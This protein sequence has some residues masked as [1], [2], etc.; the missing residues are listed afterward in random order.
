MRCLLLCALALFTAF[1]QANE[2]IT[3]KNGKVYT[4]ETKNGMPQAIDDANFKTI[5]IGPAFMKDPKTG[6]ITTFWVFNGTIKQSGDYTLVI[7]S[8]IDESI[9]TELEVKGPGKVYHQGL[10]KID[11]PTAWTWLQDA[12][13]SWVPFILTF[14]HADQAKSFEITQWSKFDTKTKEMIFGVLKKF[15]AAK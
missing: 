8:P 4:V 7:T 12:G 11:A 1:L 9:R 6:S 15:A 5:G 10:S 3:L 2:K 14:K 13:D